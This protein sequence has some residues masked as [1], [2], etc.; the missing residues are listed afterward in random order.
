[1][2]YLVIPWR[3]QES[4]VKGFRTVTEHYR[5]LV[6]NRMIF[7]DSGHKIFN[8]GAS[9]NKGVRLAEREGATGI[10][11]ADADFMAPLDVVVE[12]LEH[13]RK[14]NTVERPGTI[15]RQLTERGNKQF[16]K[17]M[18]LEDCQYREWPFCG[19]CRV[20]TP[21]AWW[22]TNGEPEC[23]RGWGFEDTAWEHIYNVLNGPVC[24]HEGVAYAF[25]HEQQR[26]EFYDRNK[27]ILENL[28]EITTK[29]NILEW[30][31]DHV[32]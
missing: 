32:G 26:A 25:W 23:F 5:P 15:Y 30:I 27:R 12:C 9:R 16:F 13:A 20:L 6:G 3:S 18:Q 14:K 8:R 7:A 4:R 1:M 28:Q 31:D 10:I 19:G 17:G 2:N 29:E 22:S 11:L 24:Q 21:Q